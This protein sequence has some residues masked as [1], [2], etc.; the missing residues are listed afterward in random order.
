LLADQ[1]FRR[2]R[3]TQQVADG[4]RKSYCS[5]DHTIL[6]TKDTTMAEPSIWQTLLTLV[7]TLGVLVWQLGALG[8]HWAF[9]LIFAA[10][11]LWAINWHKTRHFLAVGGWAPAVLLILVIALVWSRIVPGTLSFFGM[12]IP[13]F[14]WQLIY[15]SLLAAFGLFLGWIQTVMHWTPHDINLDPPAP[16]HGHGHG[17]G[18]HH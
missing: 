5:F 16:A 11:C 17:H 6:S 7:Q 8:A 4:C 2:R 9:W 18:H 12:L 3:R 15:V 14:W 13:N 1:F 10:I